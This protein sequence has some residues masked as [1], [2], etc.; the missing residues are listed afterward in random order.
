MGYSNKETGYKLLSIQSSVNTIWLNKAT[1]KKS[2]KIKKIKRKRLKDKQKNVAYKS[3]HPIVES[4]S[5]T[6]W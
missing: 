4:V 6:A 1:D 2:M 3:L 5:C